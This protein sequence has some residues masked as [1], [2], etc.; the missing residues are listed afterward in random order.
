VCC[1]LLKAEEKRAI[2]Q[3]EKDF[4]TSYIKPWKVN[5]DGGMPLKMGTTKQ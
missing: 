1:Q 4:L 3:E 5:N 2:C